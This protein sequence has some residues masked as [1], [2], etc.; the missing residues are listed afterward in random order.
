MSHVDCLQ[1][2][3]ETWAGLGDAILSMLWKRPYLTSPSQATRLVEVRTQALYLLCP[4]I[5][6]QK[7]RDRLQ[8]KEILGQIMAFIL[9]SREGFDDP[10]EDVP[11]TEFLV[12]STKWIHECVS[13][14]TIESSNSEDEL[15]LDIGPNY[16]GYVLPFFS[17][18]G[19]S[20]ENIA[21]RLNQ[22]CAFH[23]LVK[24]Q[25]RSADSNDHP[26]HHEM[27]K[28][29]VLGHYASLL[30]AT[31]PHLE[32]SYD[33]DI[34]ASLYFLVM[35]ISFVLEII[36]YLPDEPVGQ[37]EYVTWRISPFPIE[38]WCVYT[39]LAPDNPA[40]STLPPLHSSNSEKFSALTS[41]SEVTILAPVI[42]QFVRLL[43][44]LPT[45]DGTI[46]ENELLKKLDTVQRRMKQSSDVPDIVRDA[47]LT[48]STPSDAE[49]C[50]SHFCSSTD[51][52]ELRRCNSCKKKYYCSRECQRRQVFP[53]IVPQF[54]LH[55]PP[56]LFLYLCA[57]VKSLEVAQKVLPTGWYRRSGGR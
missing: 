32:V 53:E 47:W 30:D 45:V 35:A 22:L 42:A 13:L 34:G 49:V 10:S 28:A 8:S 51:P 52:N 18:G 55:S 20:R 46:G 11:T 50:A 12:A 6:F 54:T 19:T 39:I 17:L 33:T 14:Y 41:T 37:L 27:L 48:S 21:D 43:V 31:L 3:F 57:R 24:N 15:R 7:R 16:Q 9:A 56:L 38:R 40:S 26:L 5:V 4:V 2:V 44:D 1:P 25:T 23:L 29:D 36:K